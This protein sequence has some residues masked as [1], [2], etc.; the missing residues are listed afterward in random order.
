MNPT[1]E[2]RRCKH[3]GG[4][5]RDKKARHMCA[6]CGVR[7]KINPVD[8]EGRPY[9]VDGLTFARNRTSPKLSKAEKKAARK[10]RWK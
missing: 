7:V 6:K 10:A 2:Q 1:E 5:V 3:D 9:G 8:S 4:T